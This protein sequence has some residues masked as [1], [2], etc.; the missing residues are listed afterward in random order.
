MTKIVEIWSY[1]VACHVAKHHPWPN[2]QK[3]HNLGG[4]TNE[5]HPMAIFILPYHRTPG[6]IKLCLAFL[7]VLTIDLGFMFGHGNVK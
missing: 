2:A 7:M 3:V 1:R 4:S 6:D 5:D